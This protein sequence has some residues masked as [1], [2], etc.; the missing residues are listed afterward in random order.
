MAVDP[1]I[2][3]IGPGAGTPTPLFSTRVRGGQYDAARDGQ[4]FLI[5]AGSGEVSLPISVALDWAKALGR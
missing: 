2:T 5:N 4:R 1:K 3:P